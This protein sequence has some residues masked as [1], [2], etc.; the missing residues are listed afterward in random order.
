MNLL[1]YYNPNCKNFY[2]VYTNH[3]LFDYRVGQ[4]NGYGHIL[5]QILVYRHNKLINVNSYSDLFSNSHKESLKS[6]LAR[7]CIRWLNKYRE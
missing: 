2:V 7:R 5:V 3:I 4:I 1:I 6:R